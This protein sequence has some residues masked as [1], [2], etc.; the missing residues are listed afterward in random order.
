ML[1]AVLAV[2][3]V[4]ILSLAGV[5]ALSLKERL[6]D[7][8]LFFLVSFSAGAILGTAY[9]DLLPEAIEIV[10][11]A[12]VFPYLALGFVSFFFLERSIYWYHG[13]GHPHDKSAGSVKRYVYLNIIGDGVHNLIDGMVIATTFLLSIPLGVA[14]TVAVIFHELPQE[15]GDFGILVFGG[16]SKRRALLFNFLSALTAFGGLILAFVL[17]DI[18]GFAGLLI[19]VSAGGFIYLAASELLPE[20]RKE[21]AVD[22]S[23]LQYVTFVLGLLMIWSLDLLPL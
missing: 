2:G 15:I 1:H 3:L 17:I 9:F 21:K 4:S 16:F 23:V 22:R 14:A 20:I 19:A 7:R 13:H 6:L 10:E 12:F 11:E 18:E 8:I 5:V